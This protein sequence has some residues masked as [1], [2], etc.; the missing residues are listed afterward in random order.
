MNKGK[1]YFGMVMRKITGAEQRGFPT[2]QLD[3][4]KSNCLTSFSQGEFCCPAPFKRE[5][6]AMES[7]RPLKLPSLLG[8]TRVETLLKF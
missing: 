1:L 3:E 6:V 8:N 4:Q 5:V 2:A 7:L